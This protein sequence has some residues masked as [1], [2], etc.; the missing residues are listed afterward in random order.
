MPKGAD[1]QLFRIA[2][3][4]V[5]N[6]VKHSGAKGARV[7]LWADEAG[8]HLVIADDGRGL[9]MG[10]NER[11]GLGLTG[12][13]ERVRL[14]KGK[15]EIVSRPGEGTTLSVLVPGAAGRASC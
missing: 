14:L 12:I 13:A 7:D 6:L 11:S 5:N 3:E 4:A 1:I 9:P 2:Q 10:G 15:H 8:V